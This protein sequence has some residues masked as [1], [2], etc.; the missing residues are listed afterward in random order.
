MSEYLV[1]S[2]GQWDKSKTREQIQDAIDRFYTWHEGM[3]QQGKMKSGQRL[4]LGGKVVNR[5]GVTDG[6]FAESKEIIGGYWFIV[7]DSLDEAARLI[8]QNPTI[9]CGLTMEVRPVEVERASAWRESNETP[10]D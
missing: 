3:R 7:A 1:L 4:A 8:A 10:H 5:H 2:R 9:E 6:P